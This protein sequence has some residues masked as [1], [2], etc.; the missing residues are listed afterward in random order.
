[1]KTLKYA[2]RF[3]IRAKS[4][5]I[6]NLL[7]LAFSLACCIILMRYIHREL[8]V[9][10][11]CT[12]REKVYAVNT[13]MEGLNH[14]SSIESYTYEPAKLDESKIDVMVDF[15]PLENDFIIVD[16]H[17]FQSQTIVTDSAFFKLFPY[18][19]LEGEL[20]LD[21]PTSVLLMKDYAKKLFGDQNPIGQVIRHSNGKELIVEGIL[22][23]PACKTTLNFD[24]VVSSLLSQMWERMPISFYQFRPDVDIEE[25]NEIGRTLRYINSP[26]YDT[27]QYTFSFMPI[28]EVYWHGEL[29]LNESLFQ[30]GQKSHLYILM[31]VCLLI[32]LTGL[33][34]FVNLYL[35]AML[36]RGKEYGLKKVYGAGALSIFRQVWLENTLL[37]FAA[38]MV[39]WLIVEVTAAPINRLLGDTFWYSPFDLWL[40]LGLLVALPLLTSVY[41]FIKYNYAPPIRSIR[42]I[43]WSNRSVRSRMWFVGIQYTLTF[44]LVVCALYFNKQLGVMT[45]TDPGF[46]T[47]NIM[48]VRLQYESRDYNLPRDEF[49][50]REEESR[51]RFQMILERVKSCPIIEN[52]EFAWDRFC[53]QSYETTY[54][55][56]EGNKAF[57]ALRR[58]SPTFFEMFDIDILEGSVDYETGKGTIYALNKSAMKALNFSSVEEAGLVEE[59]R[60]RRDNKTSY[61]TVSAI[62][63]DYYNGH[64]VMGAQPAIYEVE[65][66]GDDSMYIAYAEGKEQELISYLTELMKDVYGIESLEY[67]FLKDDVNKLYDEDRKVT[68]IY[69]IFAVVAII[70]SCLGLFGISLFDIRQR[71]REIGIRKVNGAKIKDLYRLLFRKYVMVLGIAFIVVTPI[72]YY[73]IYQYTQDF[74]VKAPIGIGIFIIALLV[75][76]V[77]SL[78]TLFWQVHKAANINPAEVVKSE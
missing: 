26:E 57:L 20:L 29:L 7:G 18:S 21:K 24:I 76:S 1:M 50:K 3:L 54:I 44:L 67:S 15:V 41:P 31:G 52:Y 62:V 49:F 66:Y 13:S 9:D 59:D 56:P 73:F 8:T 61:H 74:V 4:Y 51:A 25:M 30:Y 23:K 65:R 33:L 43:G 71:Y 64:L 34:N 40:S 2:A 42:S 75:V 5:T 19:L 63:E 77:I 38:L 11:H 6:I 68:T 60:F 12:D 32:F 28:K 36:R 22:D 17:R 37:L 27:R 53:Q 46:R 48:L 69:N 10:T 35:V 58:V 39:A 14:I 78:G 47:E 70:I 72:A 55:T 45:S 16:N